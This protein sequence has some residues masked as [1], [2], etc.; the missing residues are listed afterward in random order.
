MKKNILQKNKIYLK[1]KC[2]LWKL[3]ENIKKK[4]K[5][6]KKLKIILFKEREYYLRVFLKT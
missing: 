2:S 6:R 3:G 1:L 4:Y 5:L